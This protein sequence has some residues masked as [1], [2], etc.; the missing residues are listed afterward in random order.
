[1]CRPQCLMWNAQLHWSIIAYSAVAG[2]AVE[3]DDDADVGYDVIWQQCM[4]IFIIIIIGIVIITI[5]GTAVNYEWNFGV[6]RKSSLSVNYEWNFGVARKSSSCSAQFFTV[7]S[8]MLIYADADDDHHH[9][10]HRIVTI[11][12]VIESVMSQAGNRAIRCA[13]WEF[14][15]L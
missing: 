8:L 12:I 10:Q 4:M 3:V 9:R 15:W 2:F 13:V 7:S 11:V 14:R 1:M 6:A 5:I